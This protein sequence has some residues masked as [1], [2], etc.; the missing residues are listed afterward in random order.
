MFAKEEYK[1]AMGRYFPHVDSGRLAS[2]PYEVEQG[3]KKGIS[4]EDKKTTAK[5]ALQSIMWPLMPKG[6]RKRHRKDWNK[7][8][9]Q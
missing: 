5:M 7:K 3:G 2:I 9:V 4:Q 6:E 1:E 8:F